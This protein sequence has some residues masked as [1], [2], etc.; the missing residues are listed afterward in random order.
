MEEQKMH[1]P[2]PY[3][4]RATPGSHD[5]E[6]YSASTGESVA[7]VLSG[8]IHGDAPTDETALRNASLLRAAPEL[9]ASLDRLLTIQPEQDRAETEASARKLLAEIAA[10]PGERFREERAEEL[11]AYDEMIAE[12][13]RE[14]ANE[15][16]RWEEMREEEELGHSF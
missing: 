5:A 15:A 11:R 9:H 10:G 16:N 3:A 4:V 13:I 12:Q 8:K 7:R 2:G 1:T 6:I 14:M